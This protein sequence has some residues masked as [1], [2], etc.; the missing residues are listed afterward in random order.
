MSLQAKTF[1]NLLAGGLA[2][3]LAWA[4]TDLTGWFSD[5]LNASQVVNGGK[6]LFYGA[7]FGALLGLLLALIETLALESQRRVTHTLALGFG[8]GAVGGLAG[9]FVGQSVYGIVAGSGGNVITSAGRFLVLLI[10][11]A[12]GWALIGA[13]GRGRAGRGKPLRRDRSA[14]SLRRSARRL[15]GRNRF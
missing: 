4:L 11:R 1:L 10:A 9:L 6:Y 14:G 2:G 8:I 7:I 5:V 12:L 3:L 15:S 13:D